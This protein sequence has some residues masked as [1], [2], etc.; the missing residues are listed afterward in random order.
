MLTTILIKNVASSEP[1]ELFKN[2]TIYIKAGQCKSINGKIFFALKLKN[3]SSKTFY[4]KEGDVNRTNIIGAYLNSTFNNARLCSDD[5]ITLILLTY[6]SDRSFSSSSKNYMALRENY[7]VKLTKRIRVYNSFVR[8]NLTRVFFANPNIFNI[9]GKVSKTAETYF[10]Y[11]NFGFE[12]KNGS[13]TID[14]VFNGY[15]E[16]MSSNPVYECYNGLLKLESEFKIE[17]N[18]GIYEIPNKVFELIPGRYY[19]TSTPSDSIIDMNKEVKEALSSGEVSAI[20]VGCFIFVFIVGFVVFWCTHH[21]LSLFSSFINTKNIVLV[22]IICLSIINSIGSIV[23]SAQMR[24]FIEPQYSIVSVDGLPERFVETERANIAVPVIFIV[25]GI[26]SW[27]LTTKMTGIIQ[28]ISI[29][30]LFSV[31]I[32]EV[33]TNRVFCGINASISYSLFKSRYTDLLAYKVLLGE[34]SLA[35]LNQLTEA[36]QSIENIDSYVSVDYWATISHKAT[37]FVIMA[38][39]ILALS[40]VYWFILSNLKLFV[41]DDTLVANQNE[42]TGF[43]QFVDQPTPYSFNS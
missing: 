2:N 24:K 35:Q 3:E 33:V 27:V 30:V 20:I 43:K 10:Y 4:L 36:E 13:F 25:L 5:N 17:G 37:S 9:K 29:C 38:Y 21:S 32:M 28:K 42:D 16:V 34:V 11:N 31:I 41:K 1:Y 18:Q 39:L 14:S 23:I 15:A 40:I 7:K 8:E 19:Y 22:I 6:N 26:L 12:D